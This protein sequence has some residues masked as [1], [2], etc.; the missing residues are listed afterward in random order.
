MSVDSCQQS[1]DTKEKSL[2][3]TTV[4]S[5][6]PPRVIFNFGQPS[7]H[8]SHTC[9]LPCSSHARSTTELLSASR[10]RSLRRVPTSL[11]ISL[12]RATTGCLPHA[13][14]LQIF[15]HSSAY[16]IF[17]CVHRAIVPFHLAAHS[18]GTTERCHGYCHYS[19]GHSP[20]M[21]PRQGP[22]APVTSSGV[23]EE[24]LPSDTSPPFPVREGGGRGVWRAHPR[25]GDQL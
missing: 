25:R 7:C 12:R 24:A 17:A 5:L 13:L 3:D 19:S 16:H 4:R 11:K 14:L 18:L 20:A 15:P 6:K 10:P 8:L 23:E 1:P 2:S 21:R 22:R 9:R